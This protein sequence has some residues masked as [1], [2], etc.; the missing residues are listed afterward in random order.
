[1]A[2]WGEEEDGKILND[3]AAADNNRAI[4][5]AGSVFCGLAPAPVCSEPP[6][7]ALQLG[8]GYFRCPF[9]LIHNRLFTCEFQLLQC[10]IVLSYFSEFSAHTTLSGRMAEDLQINTIKLGFNFYRKA[11]V[12][13]LLANK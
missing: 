2:D 5:K 12:L 7:V 9:P 13:V 11:S 10:A 4:G 1:M 6:C 8:I 3:D